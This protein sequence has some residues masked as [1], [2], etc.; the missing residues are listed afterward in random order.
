MDFIVGL[1][2]TRQGHDAIFV[3]VDKLTK[4]VHFIPNTTFVIT[5]EMIQLFRVHVFKI[6]SVPIENN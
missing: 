3:C 5:K 4:M 6:H 2:P 1:S